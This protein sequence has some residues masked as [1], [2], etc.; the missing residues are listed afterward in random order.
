MQLLVNTLPIGAIDKNM[1]IYR[2]D[3]H[4]YLC[5]ILAYFQLAECVAREAERQVRVDADRIQQQDEGSEKNNDESEEEDQIRQSPA[6][7]ARSLG[8]STAHE[9]EVRRRLR[10]AFLK[11]LASSCASWSLLS[12]VRS[13][14][15]QCWSLTAAGRRNK[16]TPPDRLIVPDLL[17]S[18]FRVYF[19]SAMA[20]PLSI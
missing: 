18:T 14:L 4:C 1:I 6:L 16:W 17:V 13:L 11:K 10:L 8:Q 9:P 19:T 15:A 12:T 3:Y 5:S 7:P 20:T 2:A